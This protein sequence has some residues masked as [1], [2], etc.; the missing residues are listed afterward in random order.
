MDIFHHGLIR[1]GA[2]R[3][4]AIHQMLEACVGR[5]IIS[6]LAFNEDVAHLGLEA[7]WVATEQHQVAV[8]PFLN[9]AHF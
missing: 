9:G 1:G 4:H 7:E 6:Q 2:F 3:L 5:A 8:L